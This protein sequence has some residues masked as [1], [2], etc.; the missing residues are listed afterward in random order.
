[1]AIVSTLRDFSYVKAGRMRLKMRGTV[2][3]LCAKT[4]G[5]ASNTCWTSSGTAPKSGGRISTPVPGFS[6]WMRRMVSA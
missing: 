5:R 2:S 6:A 4:S 3:R 1:M